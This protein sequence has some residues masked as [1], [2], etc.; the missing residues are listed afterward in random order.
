VGLKASSGHCCK[1]PSLGPRSMVCV[2][3]VICLV[4]EKKNCVIGLGGVFQQ[5][6]PNHMSPHF[7]EQTFVSSAL[8]SVTRREIA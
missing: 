8:W 2:N 7:Y 6:E 4:Q 3:L 1:Y 5:P